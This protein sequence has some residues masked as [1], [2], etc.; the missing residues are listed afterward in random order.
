MKKCSK[1]KENKEFSDF[2]KK[3]SS[4]TGCQAACKECHKT[5]KRAWRA[6][7]PDHAKQWDKN[8]KYTPE[9]KARRLKIGRARNKFYRDTLSDCYIANLIAMNS[10][11]KPQEIS[12]EMI[13]AQRVLLKLK[14][15]LG[16]T[17]IKE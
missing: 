10:E 15:V 17:N 11:L 14:R 16:L 6:K 5:E 13:Q 8:R 7:N 2:Y 9:A 12:Q 3:K 4:K 1:C